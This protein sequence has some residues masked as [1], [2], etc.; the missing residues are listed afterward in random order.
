MPSAP[1]T[2]QTKVR[3]FFPASGNQNMVWELG[4]Q[5]DKFFLEECL[6]EP[7]VNITDEKIVIGKHSGLPPETITPDTVR[8][9]ENSQL[10]FEVTKEE[11]ARIFNEILEIV[12]DPLKVIEC[13]KDFDLELGG[14]MAKEGIYPPKEPAFTY[15]LAGVGHF[16]PGPPSPSYQHYQPL[17][18]VGLLDKLLL[19]HEK[20]DEINI[21][22]YAPRFLGYVDEYIAKN[23]VIARKELFTEDQQIMQTIFHGA[24]THRL[25]FRALKNAKL[26]LNIQSRKEP[27]NLG[28]L[29]QMMV[30]FF[31]Y[32]RF[33]GKPLTFWDF[34]IDTVNDSGATTKANS[35]DCT[36]FNFSCRSPFVLNS[37]LL[38]FPQL[39]L[40]PHLHAFL[41]D[42]HYKD[43]YE[44]ICRVKEQIQETVPE[45]RIY[46]YCMNMMATSDKSFGSGEKGLFTRT[47]EEAY[48]NPHYTNM[49]TLNVVKIK[50]NLSEE[51]KPGYYP[52]GWS[53]F[54]SDK[55]K[56]KLADRKDTS[57]S[58]EENSVNPPKKLRRSARIAAK[59][60]FS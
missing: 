12:R 5:T 10:P 44:M 58:D 41:L 50:D 37:L 4:K 16:I 14:A 60:K 31:Y 52:G 57:S 7:H 28:E 53:G 43:S 34:L 2:I 3:H 13:L 30:H 25:I 55:K 15:L 17:R 20:D 49:I 1:I 8:A 39:A 56:R 36:G 11:A 46:Y 18:K 24:Y 9:S 19:Q 51:K 35:L 59:L 54:Y 21:K 26:N 33:E 38:C 45:D 32:K 29:L 23:F 40:L 47:V 27:L 48:Q 42:K 6:K 22:G